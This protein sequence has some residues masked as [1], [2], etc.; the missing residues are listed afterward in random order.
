[1]P[2]NTK[3][4]RVQHGFTLYR[5]AQNQSLFDLKKGVDGFALYLLGDKGYPL[6]GWI[7][8]PFKEKRQHSILDFLYNKNINKGD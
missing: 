6:I 4:S 5:H 2:G 1:M 3:D 8:A 7:M